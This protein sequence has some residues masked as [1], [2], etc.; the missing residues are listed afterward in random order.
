MSVVVTIPVEGRAYEA[1]VGTGVLADAGR[2]VA[3]LEPRQVA[4]V[5]QPGASVYADEVEDGLRDEAL[6][7]VRFDMAEGEAAKSWS[8][9]GEILERLAGA[10]FHRDDVVVGVGGGVVTDTAGFVAAT[11][12]RGVRWIACP[13]TLLGALDAAIGGKT[14]VNLL[15]GKNL[16]GAFW[17]PVAVLVDTAAFST[18]PRRE[19]A[20]GLA[21]A[22]KYGF[23]DDPGILDI[24]GGWSQGEVQDP[25]HEVPDA[26]EDVV[27]RGMAVK[28]R[29]VAEDER[30]GGLRA[31]LNYGHTLGHALETATGYRISHGEAVSVGMVFA[32]ELAHELGRIDADVVGLHRY[33]LRHVGLPVQAAESDVVAALPL[34]RRDKKAT[35]RGLRFV[36]LDGVGAPVIVEDVDEAMVRAAATRVTGRTQDL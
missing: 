25:V 11:L 34:M 5:T 30:E 10:E 20:G 12:L 17:Q 36:L 19:M 32:A 4:V 26:L 21:E 9:A 2:T 16:A 33:V 31:V 28:A 13:T 8:T 7:V 23:I 15:A 18:L 22:L 14:A 29:I 27:A 35:V 3:A 6:R 1:T 24:V